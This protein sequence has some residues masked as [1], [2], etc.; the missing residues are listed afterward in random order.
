LKNK[1]PVI[2][3]LLE[4][5]EL[6]KLYSTYISVLPELIHPNTGRLHARFNPMGARTG[7]FSSGGNGV[8]L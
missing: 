7:R 6:V 8:N 3:E 1:F 4:Y 5:K 2:A